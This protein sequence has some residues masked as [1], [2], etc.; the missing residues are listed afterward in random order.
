MSVLPSLRQPSLQFA[1]SKANQ[2]SCLSG[3]SILALF[4]EVSAREFRVVRIVQ[5][6]MG[7]IAVLGNPAH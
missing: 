3:H 5:Y 6:V 2:V 7:N 4:S 1:E